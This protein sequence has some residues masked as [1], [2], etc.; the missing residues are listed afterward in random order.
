[1][2]TMSVYDALFSTADESLLMHNFFAFSPKQKLPTSSSS[3]NVM[4]YHFGTLTTTKAELILQGRRK[5]TFLLR[6]DDDNVHV[7]SYVTATQQIR[8]AVF[9]KHPRTEKYRLPNTG[10]WVSTLDQAIL[11][12]S[13]KNQLRAGLT[14]EGK[15]E[16][17]LNKNNKQTKNKKTNT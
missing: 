1:M 2:G 3:F 8:H 13:Y 4:K 12:Y 11:N 7:L 14:Y 17:E 5:G 10:H 9:F 16:E 6:E 15:K